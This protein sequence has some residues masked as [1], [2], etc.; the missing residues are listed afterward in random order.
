L[1]RLFLNNSKYTNAPTLVPTMKLT[2]QQT[3]Q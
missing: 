2:A 3:R 1:R